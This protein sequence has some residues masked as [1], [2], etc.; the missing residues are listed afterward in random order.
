MG[1]LV[2]LTSAVWLYN[3]KKNGREASPING[4]WTRHPCARLPDCQGV[5]SSSFIRHMA[6][7]SF[8]VAFPRHHH[9]SPSRP[10]LPDR[11][12]DPDPAPFAA[13]PGAGGGGG[14]GEG[15]GAGA[16]G[17]SCAGDGR[18][19]HP[20]SAGGPLVCGP[21]VSVYIMYAI[22]KMSI[23]RNTPEVRWSAARWP[24]AALVTGG[25]ATQRGPEVRWSA[26]RWSEGGPA[27]RR[28]QPGRAFPSRTCRRR[29]PRARP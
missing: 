16:A 12:G 22:A 8:A 28:R 3:G 20:A 21:R 11:L 5:P 1:L 26:A 17:C 2:P 19:C 14:G 6:F 15:G 24:A 23:A 10:C 27:R 7:L 4:S 18:A 13:A 29:S 25:L 9:Q